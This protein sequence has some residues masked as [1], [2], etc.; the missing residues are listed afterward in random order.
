M[1]G[2]LASF[3]GAASEVAQVFN[4]QRVPRFEAVH[5]APCQGVQ[6]VVYKTVFPSPKPCPEALYAS[7]A[8][9]RTV[10]LASDLGPLPQVVQTLPLEGA[11]GELHPAG[12]GGEG[13]VPQ[14]Q[15]HHSAPLVGGS[16]VSTR[17]ERWMYHLPFDP[18]VNTPPCTLLALANSPRW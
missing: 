9:G 13:L 14:V 1:P 2:F 7:G 10:Q 16:G 4:R 18:L 8:F 6:G 3:G 15:A 17:R 11:A 5:D 12:E